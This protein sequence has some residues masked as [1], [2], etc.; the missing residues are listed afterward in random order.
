[1]IGQG[2]DGSLIAAEEVVLLRPTLP[3]STESFAVL[4]SFHSIDAEHGSPQHGMEFA[5]C[6]FAQTCGTALDDAGD[7]AADGVA[8]LFHFEDELLH[9]LCHLCIGTAHGVLLYEAEVVVLVVLVQGNVAHLRSVCCHADAQLLQS[10]LGKGS[11][12]TA[13]NGLAG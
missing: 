3:H 11:T 7:D 10:H 5:E 8:L 13:R 1:M 6:R 2:A 4:K 9:L 12:H